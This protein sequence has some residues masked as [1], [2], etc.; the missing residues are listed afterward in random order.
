MWRQSA[1]V[2]LQVVERMP[3]RSRSSPASRSPAVRID[4]DALRVRPPRTVVTTLARWI[5]A[6]LCSEIRPKPAP[7]R[8]ARRPRP[9]RPD[10]YEARSAAP[11]RSRTDIPSAKTAPHR[12]DEPSAQRQSDVVGGG[13]GR[14]ALLAGVR[15]ARRPISTSEPRA[16]SA[17]GL[18]STPLWHVRN[19]SPAP[20]H[21]PSRQSMRNV[22][23][24]DEAPRGPQVVPPKSPSSYGRS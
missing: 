13:A 11:R 19:L 8:P 1:A 3:S 6:T 5:R 7:P 15:H 4:L 22:R 9:C 20:T 23:R 14:P 2:R 12:P 24:A 17:Y 16:S 10:V 21:A 18:C